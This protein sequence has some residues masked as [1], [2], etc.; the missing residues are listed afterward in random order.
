VGGPAKWFLEPRDDE[1]LH[2]ILQR[3]EEAGVRLRVLG[4]GSNILV[5]DG[6]F[7]GA[8]VRLS[9]AGYGQIRFDGLRVWAGAAAPLPRVVRQAVRQGLSGLECVAGVPGT[10]G[11]GARNNAGGRFGQIGV[12]VRRVRVMD[13]NGQAYEREREELVFGYRSSNLTNRFILGAEFELADVGSEEVLKRF[14]EIWLYKRNTQPGGGGNAGCVFKNPPGAAAGALIEQ[15]GLKGWRVGAAEVSQ[16][17]ANFI[18]A[19]PGAT[20]HDVIKLIDVVKNRV[21]ARF[22]VP[23]ELEIEIW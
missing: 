15:A 18:V 11:G 23:L 22:G 17:H 4:A 20:A 2:L 21:Y 12:S 13:Q 8:V 10:V 14:R 19:G 5:R 1:Q 7:D 6:G 9:E 16:R 3:C